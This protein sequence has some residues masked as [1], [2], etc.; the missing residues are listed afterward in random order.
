MML[1]IQGDIFAKSNICVRM[2]PPKFLAV[3]RHFI[4]NLHSRMVS[5]RRAG[6]CLLSWLTLPVQS[7]SINAGPFFVHRY[8]TTTPLN[9]KV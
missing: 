4:S 2:V 7:H 8:Y 1:G 9:V 3:A 6:V 5:D